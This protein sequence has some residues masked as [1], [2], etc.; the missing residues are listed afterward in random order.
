VAR[1]L[2]FDIDAERWDEIGQLMVAEYRDG[3]GRD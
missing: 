3:E 1:W 2:A